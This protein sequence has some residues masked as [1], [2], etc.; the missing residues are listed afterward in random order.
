MRP[1][2]WAGGSTRAS[3]KN[4][5][6]TKRRNRKPV[7]PREMP[8]PKF[9]PFPVF[10]PVERSVPIVFHVVV[11]PLVGLIR[12]QGT[13]LLAGLEHRDR[14]GSHLH[15]LSGAGIPSHPCLP[16][17]DLESAKTPHPD[18]VVPRD[19]SLECTHGVIHH[20]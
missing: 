7:P 15:R 12:H 20:G 17:R 6:K 5:Q 2:V 8:F 18:V 3:V 1:G 4:R 16:A 19:T 9:S 13:Q 14:A 10:S 11:E